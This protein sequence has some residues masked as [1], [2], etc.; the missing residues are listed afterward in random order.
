MKWS[1]TS[2]S[3]ASERPPHGAL[4]AWLLVAAALLAGCSTVAD[5]A[6]LEPT[7]PARAV[8]V[9][10]DTVRVQV[11]GGAA[12]AGSRLGIRN[13][14]FKAAVESAL[15]RAGLFNR[16]VPDAAA[17]TLAATLVELRQPPGGFTMTS[18]VEVGW[19]LVRHADSTPLLRRSLATTH[20]LGVSDA[21]GGAT[22][23]RMTLE[24]AAR[25]N[26]EALLQ[27]LARLP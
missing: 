24:G 11:S 27:E 3:S 25:K 26:I 23:A 15:L 6:A 1:A 21:L 19:S 13:D 17:F 7:A 8:K 9:I 5:R 18:E 2:S 4:A 14:D 10:G 12:D 20:T 22:R 16:V